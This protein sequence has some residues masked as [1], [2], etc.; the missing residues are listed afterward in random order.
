MEEIICNVYHLLL[1]VFFNPH[2]IMSHSRPHSVEYLLTPPPSPG[3]IY[4]QSR[5]PPGVDP[6]LDSPSEYE[7]EA[8]LSYC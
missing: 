3:N 2:I 4:F 6:F 1:R 5:R 7:S 8:F